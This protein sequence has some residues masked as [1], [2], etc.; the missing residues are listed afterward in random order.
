MM[1]H[2]FENKG[3]SA[4]LACARKGGERV[5]LQEGL[6]VRF[7]GWLLYKEGTFLFFP[8]KKALYIFRLSPDD[9]SR[10]I[11]EAAGLP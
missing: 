8:E 10:R 1:Q 7:C 5:M 2:C 9:P 6:S 4:C 11:R 3:E